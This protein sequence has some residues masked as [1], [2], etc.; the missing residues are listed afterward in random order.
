MNFKIIIIE[1]EKLAVTRI[2]RMLN[3]LEDSFEIVKEIKSVQEGME[4]FATNENK[5]LDFILSDIQLLDGIS[6]EIFERFSI[7][8]P[9][10]FTTAYDEYLLKAFKN[11]GIEYLLKPFSNKELSSAIE[12]FKSLK[13]APSPSLQFSEA[14]FR[15][16]LKNKENKFPTLISYARDKIIPVKTEDVVYF[17]LS[18]QSVFAHTENHKWLLNESLNQIEDLLPRHHF[19]RANRQFIIQRKYIKEIEN[20]FGGKLKILATIKHEEILISKDNCKDFKDWL[21][22]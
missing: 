17:S 22:G 11:Y 16:L 19:Y 5:P 8:T 9:I 1:D 21:K 6:F 10:I 12:K 3:E 14:L 7:T 20:Y 2:K 13:K 4:W 15:E 18:H